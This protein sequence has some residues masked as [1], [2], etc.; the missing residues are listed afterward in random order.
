MKTGMSYSL[1]PVAVARAVLLASSSL[2]LPVIAA[3]KAQTEAV[4]EVRYQGRG[5]PAMA[6]ITFN[7]GQALINPLMTTRAL[8]GD[9]DVVQARSALIASREFAE[10]AEP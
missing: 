8:P 1:K 4:S 7:S 9:G 6:E 2:A 5:A 10:A 3:D